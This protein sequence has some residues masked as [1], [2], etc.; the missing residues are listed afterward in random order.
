MK[1]FTSEALSGSMQFI[2]F[3]KFVSLLPVKEFEEDF[4]PFNTLIQHELDFLND[5][6]ESTYKRLSA[7]PTEQDKAKG[8][9]M[10]LAFQAG[11]KFVFNDR[12]IELLENAVLHSAT[13]WGNPNYAVRLA[14]RTWILVDLADFE[15]IKNN[16]GYAL[17]CLAQCRT[18][19][20][21]VLR[22]TKDQAL[23][24]HGIKL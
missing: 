22:V 4:Y 12:P 9:L 23:K 20:T 21:Q 10:S 15:L 5:S 2:S 16:K 13:N 3:D 24:D 6:N 19:I 7:Y 1:S 11:L 14:P 8:A 18:E 17:V